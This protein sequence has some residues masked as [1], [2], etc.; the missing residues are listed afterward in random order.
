MCCWSMSPS[1]HPREAVFRGAHRARETARRL[2]IALHVVDIRRLCDAAQDALP[3]RG[4]AAENLQAR[5][6]GTLLMTRSNATGAL[7]LACG[8][9]SELATGCCTLYGDLAGGLAPLG[10]LYKSGVYALAR[11]LNIPK[12]VIPRE[13]LTRPPT[14]ELRQGQTDRD[15]LPPYPRLDAVLRAFVEGRERPSP[16]RPQKRPGTQ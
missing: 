12:G 10:D 9:K 14:A 2:G 7:A 8:N 5:V 11:H 15:T 4:I 6:R 3:A 1:A 13:V 16:H